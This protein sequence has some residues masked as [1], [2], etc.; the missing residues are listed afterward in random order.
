MSDTTAN[1][2]LPY[3][4]PSQ[5]Q[6]HVTHNQALQL[7]DAATHLAVAGELSSPPGIA[8]EGEVY[9]ISDAPD[10]AWAGQGGRLAFLQDGDWLF[11]EPRLGWRGWF[12]AEQRLR[13]FS[14]GGWQQLPLPPEGTMQQ[15]GINATPDPS[16]RLAISAPASLFNNAGSGHQIKVNK[17]AVADTASLLFQTGW[18]GRAEMGLAGDDA[19]SIKVSADGADWFTALSVSGQGHVQLPNR[20][21]ARASLGSGLVTPA[22]GAETGFDTIH[23]TQ[24]GFS[25]GASIGSGLGHRMIVPATGFHFVCLSVQALAAGAYSIAAKVNGITEIAAT[26][27][28]TTSGTWTKSTASAIAFLNAGDWVSL[29]HTGAAQLNFGPGET[30]LSLFLL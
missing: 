8:A 24:G 9:L 13:V 1:L 26:S 15:L 18:S 29:F 17:A 28:M 22:N 20:P 7:L 3:I 14:A 5:A 23:D 2:A 6:K 4:L 12:V 21:L 10:G 19:F 25:L 27:G 30:E 11:I 16:N